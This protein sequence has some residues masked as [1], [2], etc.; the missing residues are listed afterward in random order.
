MKFYLVI[1]CA[2][3]VAT[4][5]AAALSEAKLLNYILKELSQCRSGKVLRQN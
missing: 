4:T 1:A 2:S 5:A 3:N